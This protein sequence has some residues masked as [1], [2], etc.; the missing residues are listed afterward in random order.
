MEGS[1]PQGAV[2]LVASKWG[3][4]GVYLHDPDDTIDYGKNWKVYHAK[5]AN[6]NSLNTDDGWGDKGYFTDKGSRIY[7][8]KPMDKKDR[9]DFIDWVD[10][11]NHCPLLLSRVRE[12]DPIRF[13]QGKWTTY[14]CRGYVFGYG[15]TTLAPNT[16]LWW[17]GED[18]VELIRDEN[19]YCE[20]KGARHSD[21]DL[22]CHE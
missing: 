20:V 7:V 10:K 2:T 14:D 19:R 18:Q 5:R 1:T 17:H 3:P 15:V 21:R 6:G 12:L 9:N 13:P 8:G 4:Y 11:Q 22:P 16:G